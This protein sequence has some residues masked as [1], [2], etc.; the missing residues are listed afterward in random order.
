[1]T[2][3]IASNPNSSTAI[4][5]RPVGVLRGLIGSLAIT[6]V[7]GVGGLFT[8]L[9]IAAGD[10]ARRGAGFIGC[11]TDGPSMTEA[12]KCWAIAAI[13][14]IIALVTIGLTAA[15]GKA[16]TPRNL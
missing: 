10:C 15:I 12:L 6:I 5:N 13:A 8:L 9:A 14:A 4:T 2:S 1:M 3:D 7:L 11:P 16:M